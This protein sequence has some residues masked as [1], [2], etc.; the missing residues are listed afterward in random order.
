[1]GCIGSAIDL[2]INGQLIV[3]QRSGPVSFPAVTVPVMVSLGMVLAFT[4]AVSN[5][6]VVCFVS[7]CM[8]D[9]SA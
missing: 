9:K 6:D 8:T 7:G 3:M 5:A 1:M 4:L 2:V